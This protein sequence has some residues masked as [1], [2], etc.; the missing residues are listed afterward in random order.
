MTRTFKS[1]RLDFLLNLCLNNKLFLN[2]D[3]LQRL[4]LKY[5]DKDITYPVL[6][7][8]L[9]E[10]QWTA[11]PFDSANFLVYFFHCLVYLLLLLLLMFFLMLIA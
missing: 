9:I 6:I 2:R 5:H 8:H 10:G 3:T 4:S 11:L 7:I 1:F